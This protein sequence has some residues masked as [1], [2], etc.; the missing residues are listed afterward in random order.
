LPLERHSSSSIARQLSQIGL[1]K[2][3]SPATIRRF[4]AAEKL[5]P[6]RFKL[7]QHIT[8]PRAFLARAKPVLRANDFFD[9]PALTE[10]I[11]K[12][13][14]YS[15]AKAQPIIW[16]YTLEKLERKLAANI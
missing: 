10:A 13:I 6:W 2:T 16:T 4:L 9:V 8:D 5:K 11:D 14:D 15:N 3:I 12:F 1:L 7:W